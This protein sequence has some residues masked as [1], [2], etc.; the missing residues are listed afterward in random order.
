MTGARPQQPDEALA[1]SVARIKG[2]NG[3]PVGAAFFIA[4]DLV[5]TCA[6]VVAYA[7]HARPQEVAA[8][9]RSR[10]MCPWSAT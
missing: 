8:G 2:Q 5:L 10:W 1:P 9:A 4:P 3:E 7:G 6:H